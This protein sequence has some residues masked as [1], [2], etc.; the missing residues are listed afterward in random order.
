MVLTATGSE[1]RR[2]LALILHDSSKPAST[3]TT[4]WKPKGLCAG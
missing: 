4:E 2:S 3:P 1:V